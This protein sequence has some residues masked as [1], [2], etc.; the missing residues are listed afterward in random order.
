[1]SQDPQRDDS[2][3]PLYAVIGATGGIGSALCHRLAENGAKLLLGGRDLDKLETLADEVAGVPVEV[4]A[5]DFGQVDDFLAE[6]K[7]LQWTLRGVVN[8]AGSLY[9]KPAHATRQSDLDDVLATNLVTAFA[10][11]RA[12]A[13]TMRQGGSVVLMSSAAA[14][15]GL[16]NHEAIGAAKAGVAG[17]ARSAAAT[18]A[19][20]GLRVNAVAPGLVDTPMTEGITSNDI[21]LQASLSLHPLGRSGQPDEVASLIAW[22]LGPESSWVSGQTWSIDGGLSGLKGKGRA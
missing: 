14:G 7:D 2:E 21:A 3:R 12:A 22:L 18:Y 9:L 20:R 8:L 19:S 4:D 11:V 5:R 15:I 6:A 1:M 13:R 10:T 17:L 16:P